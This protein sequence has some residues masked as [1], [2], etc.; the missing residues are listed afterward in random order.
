MGDFWE[1]NKIRSGPQ[2]LEF[3][4]EKS[5]EKFL[6]IDIEISKAF[7]LATSVVLVYLSAVSE[8]NH[9]FFLAAFFLFLTIIISLVS[10]W[11]LRYLHQE[12]SLTTKNSIDRFYQADREFNQDNNSEKF[13]QEV[14]NILQE[15][16]KN[17]IKHF[18]KWVD[19]TQFLS[20][21]FFTIGLIFTLAANNFW[22]KIPDKIQMPLVIVILGLLLIFLMVYINK[23]YF[24]EA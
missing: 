18:R 1:K 22:G 7:I 17:K 8:L 20:L 3:I 6:E 13:K 5:R 16:G 12:T 2:G 21:S 4:Y 14:D 19:I 11:K 10:L 15:K 9:A 24:P 23:K